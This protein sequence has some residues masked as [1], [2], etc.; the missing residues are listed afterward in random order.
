MTPQLWVEVKQLF[1]RVADLPASEREQ[2]LEDSGESS[3][4]IAEVCRLLANI[5]AA[6]EFMQRPVSIAAGF[7]H[8]SVADLAYTEGTRLADRDRKS[9]V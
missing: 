1:D 6:G 7:R 2:A 8:Y 3:E 5:D 4:I 9:V